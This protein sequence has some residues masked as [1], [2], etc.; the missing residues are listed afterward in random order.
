MA[1]GRGDAVALLAERSDPLE[2]EPPF[3]PSAYTYAELTAAVNQLANALRSRGVKRGDVVGIF[4]A[5]VPETSIA[6]L[7]CAR[8]GAV[9]SVSA[10]S[11]QSYPLSVL[12]LTFFSRLCL[13]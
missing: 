10:F 4:M 11:S 7:A 5:H 8:I 12:R 2:L 9:H 6:M 1:L 13:L 3:Q